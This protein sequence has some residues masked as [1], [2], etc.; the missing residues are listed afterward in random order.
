MKCISLIIYVYVYWL[1]SLPQ[2]SC[3]LVHYLNKRKSF[4]CSR[5]G[6]V[7]KLCAE[8]VD[9][10][11]KDRVTVLET[12]FELE[13]KRVND[14]SAQINSVSKEVKE[15]NKKLAKEMKDGTE[16]LVKE[17]KD[18]KEKLAKEMKDGN[19]DLVKEMKDGKEKLA[20]EMKDLA[21]EM[22]DGN[23]K[24]SNKF[25]PLYIFLAVVTTA[26]GMANF[27]DLV[28]FFK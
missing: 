9:D 1:S 12:K 14:L 24:L 7:K 25:V 28:A 16:K 15:G 10:E 2:S 21:K 11:L 18:G 19:E 17:M 13:Q 5:E 27:K 6:R 3:F 4:N 23:E 8:K 26:G 22:K 20:K